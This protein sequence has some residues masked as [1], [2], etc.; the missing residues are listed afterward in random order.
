M[1]VIADEH[2]SSFI[3]YHNSFKVYK[4]LKLIPRSHEMD[5]ITLYGQTRVGKTR[6]AY[7][8]YPELYSVPP[9]KQ[10]GC[11]WDG[12]EG[13]ATVLI[14]EMYGNRFSH[15]FLLQLLDRYPFQ[16]PY[17]GGQIQFVSTTIIICSNAYPD[18]WYNQEKFPFQNG[19]LQRRL[20]QGRSRICCMEHGQPE[21]LEGYEPL[22]GPV[23]Q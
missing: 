1:S 17:H 8:T 12:Y 4:K 14:D 22:I 11:Y 13:Q 5:I 10:S 3:R 2:F 15:G 21:T 9:A 6:W 20:I 18:E 19:P 7:F 16:V 23:N